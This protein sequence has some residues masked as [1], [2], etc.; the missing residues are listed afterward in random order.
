MTGKGKGT[1]FN[2]SITKTL[3]VEASGCEQ[4]AQSRY[5]ATLQPGIEPVTSRSAVRHPTFAL[6]RHPSNDGNMDSR[7]YFVSLQFGRGRAELRLA[8]PCIRTRTEERLEVNS[9]FLV[10]GISYI[11]VTYKMNLV[12]QFHDAL[13]FVLQKYTDLHSANTTVQ[14]VILRTVRPFRL[15]CVKFMFGRNL[16]SPPLMW[17]MD[18]SATC[19]TR[20]V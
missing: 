14:C 17:R 7:I 4:L 15:K 12:L 18:S 10:K 6:P 3:G 1:R 11:N 20:R 2:D 5:A 8:F 16:S 9:A 13:N 19:A